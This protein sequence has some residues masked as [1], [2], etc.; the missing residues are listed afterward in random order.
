MVAQKV[1]LMVDQ[2]VDQM[3]GSASM[4]AAPSVDQLGTGIPGM[5]ARFL[6]AALVISIHQ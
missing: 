5:S 6:L 3:A 1:A 2:T 4:K